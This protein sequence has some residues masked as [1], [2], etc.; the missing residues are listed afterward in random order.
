MGVILFLI[1][2]ILFLPL[3][4]ATYCVLLAKGNHKGYFHSSALSLDIYA[5]RE[6]R[7]LW[8]VTLRKPYSYEFG[9]PTET[10]SSVL[11]KLQRDKQLTTSGKCLVWILDTLDKNHCQKS[12]M[13]L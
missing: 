11:G 2:Y 7:T 8:N 10:I 12:I 13:E 4:V 3:S 1:A 9:A 5:N 6:F